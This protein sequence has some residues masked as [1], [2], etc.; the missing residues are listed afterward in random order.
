MIKRN[1]CHLNFAIFLKKKI[2]NRNSKVC[3]DK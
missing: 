2:K 1:Q 3:S